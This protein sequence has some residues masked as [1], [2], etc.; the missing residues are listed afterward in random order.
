MLVVKSKVAQIVK[1]NNKRM[2]KEAWTALDTRVRN[3]VEAA[4]RSTGGFKTIKETEI[5]IA[6]RAK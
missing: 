4:I 1:D 5:L 6:D 3:I 2:S